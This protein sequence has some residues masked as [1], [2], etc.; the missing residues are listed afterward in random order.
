MSRRKNPA[1]E[2]PQAVDFTLF[3]KDAPDR[4]TTE[5]SKRERK[6]DHSKS[7]L[8]PASFKSAM[9]ADEAK[10]ASERGELGRAEMPE[11]QIW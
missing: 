11:N 7:K 4:A 1:R 9:T 3:R 10:A 8:A 5:E 2:S 6:L